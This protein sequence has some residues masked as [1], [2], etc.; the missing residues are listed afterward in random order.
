MGC[1]LG[2]V[3]IISGAGSAMANTSTKV[4]V[5]AGAQVVVAGIWGAA[6][7]ASFVSGAPVRVDGGSF[8]RIA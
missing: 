2:R 7:T 1:W 4:F 6:D 8:A 5:R 3:A